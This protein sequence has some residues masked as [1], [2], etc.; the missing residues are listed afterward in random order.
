MSKNSARIL[1]HLFI[2]FERWSIKARVTNKSTIRTY[3]NAK[4]DGKLFNVEFIDST[5]QIRA[6]GFNVQLDK[7]YDML[8]IDSVSY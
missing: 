2:S 1:L 8:N 4:G 7:F 6:S 3:S 5:G